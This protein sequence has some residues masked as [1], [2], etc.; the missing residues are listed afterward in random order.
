MAAIRLMLGLLR[1]TRRF[2]L[3]GVVVALLVLNAATLTVASVNAAVA[4]ALTAV[5]GIQTVAG[6]LRADKAGL[7]QKNTRLARKNEA[8][9]KAARSRAVAR[10]RSRAI[11]SR[12]QRRIARGAVR[13]VGSVAAESIPMAGI[14]VV[15]GVT[16]LELKEACDTTR[17]LEALA[18]E[19]GDPAPA[20][21]STT[22]CGLTVPTREQ[23]ATR[24]AGN[25]SALWQDARI[26]L[27]D[28]GHRL[29]S[30]PEAADWGRDICQRISWDWL[31]PTPPEPS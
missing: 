15:L 27:D 5:T 24:I 25:T 3:L 31:C 20:D 17:D 13:N 29:P 14:A 19:L 30:L 7:A 26:W 22:V 4:G 28:A 12:V 18:A 6:S 11:V 2:A 21:D 10:T 1:W 9:A 8:M 16:A 23:I